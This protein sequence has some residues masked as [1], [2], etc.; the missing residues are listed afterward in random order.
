MICVHELSKMYELLMYAL[1]YMHET[2]E[3]Y[4]YI[5]LC[6]LESDILVY[7]YFILSTM[8]LKVYVVFLKYI[9]ILK[10][11]TNINENKKINENFNIFRI[12]IL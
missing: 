12:K 10:I 7:F 2:L 1:I 9:Y 3:Y 8:Y 4:R 11:T 5:N 6:N